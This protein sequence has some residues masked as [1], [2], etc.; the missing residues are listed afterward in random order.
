MDGTITPINDLMEQ[1]SA[2]VRREKGTTASFEPAEGYKRR[3]IERLK[4]WSDTHELWVSL[5]EL[6]V[7]FLERGGENEVYTGNHDLVVYKLNNFEYA[8]DDLENFF[9][10]MKVHNLLF[11]NVPYTLIGFAYNSKDEFCAVL[12]QPFVVADREATESEIASY[13]KHLGFEMDY[14]DEFHT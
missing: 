13:M 3:Q 12:V 1:A 8:G 14:Y 9:L 4:S 5:S 11:R 7:Y 2:L 10:R 6:G